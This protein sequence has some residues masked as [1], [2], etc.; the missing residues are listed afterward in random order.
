FETS[1]GLMR[2]SLRSAGLVPLAE[3]Y[4]A[5]GFDAVN[6]SGG[7]TTTGAVLAVSGSASVVDWVR[8]ELRHKNN[9][10]SVVAVRHA[11]LLRNGNV[12]DVDGTSDVAF[13]VP[14]DNYHIAVRHRNHLGAMLATPQALSATATL[15]DLTLSA[16]AL[17]GG[18]T[19]TKA[20]NGVRCL[21][22]G[23]ANVSGHVKYS[24]ADNDRDPILQKVGGL[25][26][27]STVNGYHREDLN[28]DGVVRYTGT[29]ND[30]DLILNNIGGTV[31]SSVLVE[32]LP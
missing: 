16:T 21:Y 3:P 27:T 22:A 26:P 4:T 8:V 24:G 23:D 32:L 12:V 15:K 31:P 5:L 17:Y 6:G 11:L 14:A 20:V 19:A 30:R 1:T 2:G 28:L 13:S 9:S 25:V 18:A 7:E 10:A 29:A